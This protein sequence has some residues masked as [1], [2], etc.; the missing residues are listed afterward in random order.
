[1][2]KPL[3]PRATS[4]IG[5]V[6]QAQ[7][8]TKENPELFRDLYKNRADRVVQSREVE[9]GCPSTFLPQVLV[10]VRG[11]AEAKLREGDMKY[12]NWQVPWP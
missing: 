8:V 12:M 5:A 10:P 9:Q 11:S 1:M 2:G 4:V 6:A 7:I 3:C